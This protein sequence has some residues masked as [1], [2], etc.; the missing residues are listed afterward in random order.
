MSDNYLRYSTRVLLACPL[1]GG[2]STYRV[3]FVGRFVHFLCVLYR[4]FLCIVVFMVL[5]QYNTHTHTHTLAHTLI[6]CIV[7]IQQIAANLPAARNHSSKK[8]LL[9][10]FVPSLT[11]Q[12]FVSC[13]PIF[14]LQVCCN[15][16][17][18]LTTVEA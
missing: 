14:R 18:A 9:N 12:T 5:L 8:I 13:L 7:R 10:S 3:S 17:Y 6:L 1:L 11:V 16:L 4:R 2:L 15:L